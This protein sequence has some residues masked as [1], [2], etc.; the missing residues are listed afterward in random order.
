MQ[1]NI[2]EVLETTSQH[3]IMRKMTFVE[4]KIKVIIMLDQILEKS[5]GKTD[6]F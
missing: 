3:Q 4:K 1:G 6:F 2:P 5:Q